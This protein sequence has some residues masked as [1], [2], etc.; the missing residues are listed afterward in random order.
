MMTDVRRSQRCIIDS[1]A[2]ADTLW[3][4]IRPFVPA[5]GFR[6][7]GLNVA[8]ASCGTQWATTC[9]AQRRPLRRLRELVIQQGDASQCTLMLYLNRPEAEETNFLNPRDESERVGV[10]PRPGL[11]LVFDHELYH[12]GAPAAGLTPSAP[13]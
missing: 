8:C 7:V 3:E 2:M 4:R 5:P 9:S 12:E 6:P 11:A 10:S 1:Q 13:T